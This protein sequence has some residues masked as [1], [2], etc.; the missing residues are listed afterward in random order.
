MSSVGT[1]GSADSVVSMRPRFYETDLMGIVHHATYLCY[2]EVGRVEWLRRRGVNYTDWTALGRHL[3]VVNIELNYKKPARFDEELNL[4]V[5]L[6]SAGAAQV[7]YRYE[8]SRGVAGGGAEILTTG[9]T[10]LAAV[11]AQ[12]ALRRMDPDMREALARPETTG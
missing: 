10:R 9:M 7:I 12:G 6:E 11:D 4:L 2:F 1:L 5:R 3:A 8:L